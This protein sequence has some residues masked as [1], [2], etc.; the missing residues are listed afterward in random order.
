MYLTVPYLPDLTYLLG[1]TTT[2]SSHVLNLEKG[3]L[4][5]AL[6]SAIAVLADA[7]DGSGKVGT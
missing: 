3:S 7:V 5:V 4:R 6:R 1:T 2:T